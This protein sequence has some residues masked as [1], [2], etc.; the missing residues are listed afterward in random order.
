LLFSYPKTSTA[1]NLSLWIR[2]LVLP[3][4]YRKKHIKRIRRTI[5]LIASKVTHGGHQVRLKISVLHRWWRD[6]VYGWQKIPQLKGAT[7]FHIVKHNRLPVTRRLTQ[8]NFDFRDLPKSWRDFWSGNAFV[9]A[10]QTFS[11]E[12]TGGAKR[13]RYSITFMEPWAFDRPIRLGGQ[14]FRILSRNLFGL[15]ERVV[16][17]EVTE[18]VPVGGKGD[19]DCGR[20]WRDSF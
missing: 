10:G 14:L 13:Q 15:A 5:G 9:G 12:A 17:R 3:P 19:A 6:F 8:R 7:G 2:D 16:L 18:H 4:F 1:Y 11:M 20:H